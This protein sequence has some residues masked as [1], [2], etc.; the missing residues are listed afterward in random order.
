MFMANKGNKRHMKSLHAPQ[1]YGVHRKEHAYVA[2]QSPGRHTLGKSVPLSAALA[3]LGIAGSMTEARRAIKEGSVTVGGKPRRS[4]SFP[5]GINDIITIKGGT[6]YLVSINE[7]GK[8]SFKQADAD[9]THYKVVGKY[10]AKDGRIMARLHDGSVLAFKS[11]KEFSVGD[12]VLVDASRTFKG[13]VPLKAGAECFIVDGVHT[14]AKGRIAELKPGNMHTGASAV[15][16]QGAG[17]KFE[18]LVRNIIVVG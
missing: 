1:Y 14:G 18:T 7:Q 17:D 10:K 6:K 9:T 4:P 12:S 8:V 11:A 16:E 5:V 13:V 3:K 2:K 15:V